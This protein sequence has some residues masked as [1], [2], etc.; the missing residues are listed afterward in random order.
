MRAKDILP[1]L[2]FEVDMSPSN[3]KRLAYK[4]DATVGMEFEM[5]IPNVTTGGPPD[6][7]D[8]SKDEDTESI[9]QI[10]EFFDRVPRINSA[11]VLS[12]LREN[13]VDNFEDWI[14]LVADNRWDDL[15]TLHALDQAPNPYINDYLKKYYKSVI[16]DELE[17]PEKKLTDE[18]YQVFWNTQ[19]DEGGHVYDTIRES[20][21]NI[22]GNKIS[23]RPGIQK[24]W[25]NKRRMQEMTD[26]LNRY[27][28]IV[29]L[30][31]PFIKEKDEDSIR[32][33]YEIAD[34]FSEFIGR[35][36]IGNTDYHEEDRET[37]YDTESYIVEPDG[38]I[39]KNYDTEAGLEFISPPL[40][41]DE[42]SYDLKQVKR[43]AKKQHA[44]T[45][46]STGVHI[47]ISIPNY[48]RK[49]LDFVKLAILSG[50]KYVLSQFG[51]TMN[52][53]ARS[54]LEYI[55]GVAKD[56]EKVE[57]LVTQLK[58]N[59]EEIASKAI[60][61][62]HT[63][64]YTSINTKDNYVEFRSPGGDWLN[65]ETF[66]KI[67]NTMYRFIVALD[68]ACD[69]QKYRKEYLKELYKLI[70][71]EPNSDMSY[72]A[73]YMSDQITKYEYT[74]LLMKKQSNR[75]EKSGII[76]ISES[77]ANDGDWKISTEGSTERAYDNRTIYLRNT[78][79]VNTEQKAAAAA[80]KLEPK[81]FHPDTKNNI[82][83]SRYK[84]PKKHEYN[85]YS[86]GLYLDT[87]TA[88]D[89][90]DAK[91]LYASSVNGTIPNNLIAK[92]TTNKPELETY[93]VYSDSHRNIYVAATTEM[94][95]AKLAKYLR[96]DWFNN[97]AIL[98]IEKLPWIS[99]GEFETML[100]DQRTSIRRMSVLRENL[101]NNKAYNVHSRSGYTNWY[102]ARNVTEAKS[103]A[104]QLEPGYFQ[105]D[106]IIEVQLLTRS[107]LESVW[108]RLTSQRI[109]LDQVQN[110][111]FRVT[112]TTSGKHKDI[113]AA[114]A[115]QAKH[116][117]RTMFFAGNGD[118]L[119]VENSANDPNSSEAGAVFNQPSARW[120][121][122]NRVN[123]E[124]ITVQAPTRLAAIEYVRQVW[125]NVIGPTTVMA[126]DILV[127]GPL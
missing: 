28:D 117:A 97:D 41:M 102:V 27:D 49:Y 40:P 46:K 65:D 37:A 25:L 60:H 82:T 92:L 87:V 34:N 67:E 124:R 44:Y 107:N 78:D 113:V 99:K 58:N 8:W 121:I 126:S 108:N 32:T 26:I 105:K 10:C 86:R 38:S 110:Y 91:E 5:I 98:T 45:N 21:I 90:D 89:P 120:H 75:L 13:L 104:I 35:H 6:P 39:D 95:A 30:R 115:A 84:K 81:Y 12:K 57:K 125:P 31:W 101:G 9:D 118:N 19:S 68:A 100:S 51:R 11:A 50:D 2:L 79:T 70:P 109:A 43:W 77:G 64:K 111:L 33:V 76:R 72:F 62:G 52:T 55:E 88:T 18:D 42:M 80:A 48:T 22:E 127:Q 59:C 7:E 112:D 96:P 16:A 122:T 74:D 23:K 83:I 17:K 56:K 93:N 85:I 14:M 29:G 119:H 4:I 61:N 66:D 24:T 1:T 53:Y 36:A 15:N 47:N 103:I 63:D 123:N 3:L 94:E 69:P 54:A 114:D 71:S 73:Q 20:F 106:F 116:I